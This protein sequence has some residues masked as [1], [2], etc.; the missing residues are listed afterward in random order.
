[1]KSGKKVVV[2]ALICVMAMTLFLV[3]CQNATGDQE[4]SGTQVATQATAQETETVYQDASSVNEI[5][6]YLKHREIGSYE[7]IEEYTGPWTAG[8]DIKAFEAFASN[9]TNIS[10]E[11]YGNLWK[12][13]WFDNDEAQNSKIGYCL[14]FTLSGGKEYVQTMIRPSDTVGEFND[15]IEVWIYDDIYNLGASWYSHL[16]EADFNEESICSSIKLTAAEKIGDVNTIKLK[17]FIYDSNSDFDSE[18]GE[19][20]GINSYEITINRE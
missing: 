7:L 19:Y 12:A 14:S 11:T 9:E 13:R 16:T 17:A 1:M 10:G 2:L 18:S 20:I 15:Y 6:L 8:I 3:S 4:T 5:G